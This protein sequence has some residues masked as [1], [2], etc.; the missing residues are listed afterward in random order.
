MLCCWRYGEKC[1]CVFFFPQRT[2][3]MESQ[4]G[5]TSQ[6]ILSWR[7]F[8]SSSP[9]SLPVFCVLIVIDL[10]YYCHG[11]TDHRIRADL[12]AICTAATHGNNDFWD[13]RIRADLVAICMAATHGSNGSCLLCLGICFLCLLR[14]LWFMHNCAKPESWVEHFSNPGLIM[15]QRYGC[16]CVSQAVCIAY[17]HSLHIWQWHGYFWRGQN[18]AVSVSSICWKTRKHTDIW[19]PC[20]YISMQA[21]RRFNGSI[22]PWVV[23]SKKT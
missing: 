6:V 9:P 4:L 11:F 12:V 13:H 10:V 1:K 21:Y 14:D 20:R 19:G 17:N 5:Y 18:M 3:T 16:I 22:N 23:S 8:L 7:S 2:T 15:R